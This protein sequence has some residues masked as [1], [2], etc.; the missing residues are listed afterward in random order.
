MKEKR[1]VKYN[2]VIDKY[3]KYHIMYT[4]ENGMPV[5]RIN[6]HNY[7]W[8]VPA[9]QTKP[10]GTR[11]DG[12]GVT[13]PAYFHYAGVV[14]DKDAA[15]L[16]AVEGSSVYAITDGKIE[17]IIRNKT[18]TPG[19]QAYLEKIENIPKDK[20]TPE[21]IYDAR[22]VPD[23][24]GKAPRDCFNLVGKDGYTY[25]YTHLRPYS[26]SKISEGL[27]VKAGDFLGEVGNYYA[28]DLTGSHLHISS[29]PT[30]NTV[31]RSYKEFHLARDILPVLY[32]Y[33]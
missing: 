32:N 9:S 17:D 23:G 14:D 4:A 7:S 29:V 25:F 28:A 33:R 15:D 8:P 5:V 19:A 11:P 16:G 31:D 30:G 10:T 24:E 27:I 21:Q 2:D 6:G 13:M 26:T 3:L 12:N 1:N 20:Q 18:S 22:Y